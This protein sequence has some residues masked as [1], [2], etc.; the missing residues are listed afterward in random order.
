MR[1]SVGRFVFV[2]A[3]VVAI[4]SVLTI[5]ERYY[6]GRS[7]GTGEGL[8]L[9]PYSAGLLAEAQGGTIRAECRDGGGTK[10]IVTLP[11]S[12]SE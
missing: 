8:G 5:F 10:F 4:G 11:T 9:G 1:I 12:R 3:S 7:A 2:A 6:R